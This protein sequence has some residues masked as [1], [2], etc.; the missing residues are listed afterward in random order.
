MK[1]IVT[2][3]LTVMFVLTSSVNAETIYGLKQSAQVGLEYVSIDSQ[4]GDR[5][6]LTNLGRQFQVCENSIRLPLDLVATVLTPD[7]PWNA[8]LHLLNRQTGASVHTISIPT[9]SANFDSCIIGYSRQTQSVMYAFIRDSQR[10]SDPSAI[11]IYRY[12]TNQLTTQLVGIRNT[13]LG[14]EVSSLAFD[15]T[16]DGFYVTETPAND[17]GPS[18]LLYVDLSNGGIVEH[19]IMDFPSSIP[20]FEQQVDPNSGVSLV[21][22]KNDFSPTNQRSLQ[23]SALS[24]QPVAGAILSETDLFSHNGEPFEASMLSQQYRYRVIIRENNVNY[25]IEHQLGSQGTT[26]TRIQDTSPLFEKYKSI[27]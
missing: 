6:A 24:W 10:P 2:T 21:V 16:R 27:F 1:R 26:R 25:L 11:E 13:A 18:T 4:T 7:L 14:A 9:L 8:S 12:D 3:L 15:S 23:F 17:N 5:Q 19:Q 20:V 22:T